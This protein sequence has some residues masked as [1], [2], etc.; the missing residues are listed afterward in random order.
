MEPVASGKPPVAVVEGAGSAE[1]VKRFVEAANGQDHQSQERW[2]TP[3]C[4]SD[5]C[6]GFARQAGRKFQV[7]VTRQQEAGQHALAQADIICDGARKC[8]E[9]WLLI[10]R[11]SDAQLGWLLSDVTEN[12]DKADAWVA[13]ALDDAKV[14][15]SGMG[16]MA[17]AVAALRPEL[18]AC[19]RRRTAKTG[20]LRVILT[21]DAGG[22]VKELRF[23]PPDF[24]PAPLQ[25]CLSAKLL[26]ASFPAS[27]SD[28]RSLVIPLVY[29]ST[30]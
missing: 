2:S 10:Q 24:G 20:K 17:K 28:T 13:P 12:D 22:N 29:D 19:S 8:D 11:A 7:V 27:E 26:S 30:H 23:D 3:A 15:S 9:V 14:T 6:G 18:T 21:I 25:S 1:F 16:A 4:W 5:E